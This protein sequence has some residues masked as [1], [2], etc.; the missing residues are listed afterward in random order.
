MKNI[1]IFTLAV[2]IF[3]III[4][5]FAIVFAGIF[6]GLLN[7]QHINNFLFTEH[8]VSEEARESYNQSVFIPM[9]KFIIYTIGLVVLAGIISFIELII[10]ASA[11]SCR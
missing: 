3:L 7:F 9:S 8:N 10:E 4:V 5:V 1:V 11:Y 2:L 6:I